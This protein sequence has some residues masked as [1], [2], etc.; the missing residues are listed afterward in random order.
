MRAVL[1]KQGWKLQT[2]PDTLVAKVFKARYYP[3]NN[4]LDSKLEHN[5]NFVWWNIF[6]AKLVVGYG[7][8]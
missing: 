7:A 4:Y 5:P 6:S 3:H 1:G 8:R 2:E